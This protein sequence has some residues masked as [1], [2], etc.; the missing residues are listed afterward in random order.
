MPRAAQ[1]LMDRERVISLFTKSAVVLSR[2][3]WTITSVSLATSLR[4]DAQRCGTAALCLSVLLELLIRD[5]VLPQREPRRYLFQ[6]SKQ[7]SLLPK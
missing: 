5:F 3:N 7:A 1:I 4:S 2:K 6:G